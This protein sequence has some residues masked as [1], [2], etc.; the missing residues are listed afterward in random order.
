MARGVLCDCAVTGG[1]G[2]NALSYTVG[3][4]VVADASVGDGGSNALR[5]SGEKESNSVSSAANGFL[6]RAY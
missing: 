3:A 4:C 5:F 1:G 6:N 2:G